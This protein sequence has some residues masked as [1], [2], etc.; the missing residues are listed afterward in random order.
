MFQSKFLNRLSLHLRPDP[1][2]VVGALREGGRE[3]D[4]GEGTG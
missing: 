4:L 2:R 3:V 1:A